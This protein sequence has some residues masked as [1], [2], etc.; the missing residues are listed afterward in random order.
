FCNQSCAPELF[1]LEGENPRVV[2]DMKGV[3]LIQ[4]KARNISTG[5]KFVKKVRS[6]L[7]KHT[8]I[9]RIV[10][11]MEPSKYYI[12]RPIQ[13]PSGNYMLTINEDTSSPRSQEKRIT[14][15]RPDLRPG[16]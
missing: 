15:L 11:D 7:D 6:Y 13:D 3:F 10:L 12:V 2:M 14:I 5:G 4:T 1:S 16:K 9:L 8:N